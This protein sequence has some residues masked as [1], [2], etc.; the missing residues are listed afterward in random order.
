MAIIMQLNGER[1]Q[2]VLRETIEDIEKKLNECLVGEKLPA[3]GS[4]DQALVVSDISSDHS[5]ITVKGWHG[6]RMIVLKPFDNI[7]TM[8]EEK[9]EIVAKKMA[10]EKVR[11]EEI[12]KQRKMED[13]KNGLKGRIDPIHLFPGKKEPH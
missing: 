6:K 11:Q 3:V 5:F 10:D 9:D 13:A 7:K 1:A 12:E 8:T 4:E 2:V